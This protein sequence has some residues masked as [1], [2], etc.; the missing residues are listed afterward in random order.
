M[1]TGTGEYTRRVLPRRL[2]L[3]FAEDRR[4]TPLRLFNFLLVHLEMRLGRTRLLSRPFELCIDVSNKCNLGCP[5]CPTGR[6]EGG[7]PK[8]NISFDSFTSIIDELA[9][10]A[11]SVELFN[12][13]EAFFNPDLPRLVAYAHEKALV[14]MISSNLSF[15]L[16][17]DDVRAV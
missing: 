9:P 3:L 15:R 7:R 4:V 13:G 10:Y 2:R 5:F 1:I 14:T 6:G 11:F 8:G 16:K 12:W 17:E